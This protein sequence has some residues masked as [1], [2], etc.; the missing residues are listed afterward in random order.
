[1]VGWSGGGRVA[2]ALAAGHPHLVRRVALVGT[3]APDDEVPWVQPE[4][5]EMSAMLRQDPGS[6]VAALTAIF[7][8]GGDPTEPAPTSGGDD[9]ADGPDDGGLVAMVTNGGAADAAALQDPELRARVEAMVGFGFQ[10]GPAGVATD[11]V[12]DQVV[13]WGFDLASIGAPVTLVYGEDDA[14]LTPAHGRWYAD[15][16]VAATLQVV[17]GAG[18]LVIVGA[19]ADLVADA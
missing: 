10:H 19:W 7:A 14:V 12:T 1:M 8:G 2:L 15:Q 4:H 6:A 11:I 18:H 9:A 17:P 5:R 3:P 16:L 13:P